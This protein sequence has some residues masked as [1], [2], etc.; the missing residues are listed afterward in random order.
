LKAEAMD[1]LRRS[2]NAGYGNADWCSKDPDLKILHD[3][4][5]F[6]KLIAERAKRAY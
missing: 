6:K 5:E 2:I 3:D 4:P 1:A